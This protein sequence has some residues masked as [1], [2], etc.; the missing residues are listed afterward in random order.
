MAHRGLVDRL[1]TVMGDAF[2]QAE[3]LDR[4]EEVSRIMFQWFGWNGDSSQYAVIVV[5]LPESGAFHVS[6]GPTDI[7]G[8]RLTVNGDQSASIRLAG[9]AVFQ[10]GWYFG[11]DQRI[12]WRLPLDDQQRLLELVQGLAETVYEH[13]EPQFLAGGLAKRMRSILPSAS[14]HMRDRDMIV[15]FGRNVDD[16]G[17][18][19][20]DWSDVVNGVGVVK[21]SVLAC[22]EDAAGWPSDEYVFDY[23]DGFDPITAFAEEVALKATNALPSSGISAFASLY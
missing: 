4:Y 8:R 1:K 6:M 9:G 15:Y 7:L 12:G 5:G 2:P 23:G 18:L 20:L 11:E 21:L 3:I 10:G 22:C 13:F 17:C 19:R 14:V 16:S